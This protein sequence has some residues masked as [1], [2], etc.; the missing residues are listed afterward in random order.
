MIGTMNDLNFFAGL[1][2]SLVQVYIYI[3]HSCSLRVPFYIG[4]LD[5]EGGVSQS[6]STQYCQDKFLHN[7][8]IVSFGEIKTLR[9]VSLLTV[10]NLK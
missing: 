9:Q 2:S 3:F 4:G 1:L 6:Q 8:Q 5:D 10:V 7:A